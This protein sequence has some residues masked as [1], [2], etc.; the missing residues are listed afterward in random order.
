MYISYKSFLSLLSIY[1]LHLILPRLCILR[2]DLLSNAAEYPK[3]AFTQ[4]TTANHKQNF[5]I[6]IA[7]NW[8]SL[9]VRY[10]EYD[11]F[12]LSIPPP[13]ASKAIR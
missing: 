3:C 13:R 5:H 4:F 10:P 12:S 7:K 6:L 2:L 8:L 9:V 11:V 1:M